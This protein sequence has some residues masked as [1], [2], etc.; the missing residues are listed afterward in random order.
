M[1]V[2]HQLMKQTYDGP[3]LVV[4]SENRLQLL[5]LVTRLL[6]DNETER[7]LEGA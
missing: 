7:N 2:S 6:R 4:S 5:N 1:W 3:D